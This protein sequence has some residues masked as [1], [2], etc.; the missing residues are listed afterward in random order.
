MGI[1]VNLPG[2][3]Q[4]IDAA[5][6]PGF[7]LLPPAPGK[8]TEIPWVWYAP[9]LSGNFPNEHHHWLIEQLGTNG[10]AFAGVDV[11]E[12]CG[13]PAGRGLFSA[14]YAEAVS[15]YPLNRKASLLPQSRG[16]MMLYNWAAENPEKVACIGGIY[17]VCDLTDRAGRPNILRAY[18]LPEA[19]LRKQLPEHNPIDRLGPLAKAGIRIFHIQG[20]NDEPV[21]LE[22]HSAVLV[23][24]YKELGGSVE[25]KVVPGGEHDMNPVFFRS[26]ALLEFFITNQ[27]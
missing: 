9:T 19:E 8:D 13:S 27:P 12:S 25:L 20:D 1:N 24:R 11:G 21:P 4:E 22:K 7:I 10:I 18:S 14:F 5:G 16:G 23:E 17:P 15:K 6:A 3:Y 2:E 26:P